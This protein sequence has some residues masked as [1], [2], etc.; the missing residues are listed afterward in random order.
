MASLVVGG[1]RL[2][3][4]VAVQWL[5]RRIRRVETEMENAQYIWPETEL[6]VPVAGSWVVDNSRIVVD[7]TVGLRELGKDLGGRKW[8]WTLVIQSS[9]QFYLFF[10]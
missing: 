6:D 9:F 7:F 5:G 1:G 2:G 10:V 8:V 4:L 3:L